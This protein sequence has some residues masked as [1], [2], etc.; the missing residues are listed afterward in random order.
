[1][2]TLAGKLTV[3]HADYDGELSSFVVTVPAMS[4]ENFAAQEA[5][6]DAFLAALANVVS[7]LRTSYAYYNEVVQSVAAPD[8]PTAQRE[9]KWTVDII[10]PTALAGYAI[11]L[12]IPKLA[13]LDENDR[14]HAA[15]GDGDVVDNFVAKLEAYVLSPDG[16]A[17]TVEEITLNRGGR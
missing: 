17:V 10:D 15:I 14:A 8:D 6:R 4:A 2:S 9:L 11:G 12:P 3:R 13:L 16:N 7:G 1:M 5:L